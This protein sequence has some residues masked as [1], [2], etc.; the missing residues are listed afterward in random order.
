MIPLTP[1]T[2][3]V[4]KMQSTASW[5]NRTYLRGLLLVFSLQDEEDGVEELTQGKGHPAWNTG[6]RPQKQQEF[7]TYVIE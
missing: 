1:N 6:R 3:Q 2:L 4:W 5:K 7:F